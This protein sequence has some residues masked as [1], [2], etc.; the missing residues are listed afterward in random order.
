VTTQKRVAV[1]AVVVATFALAGVL[2]FVAADVLRWGQSVRQG[3]TRFAAAAGADGMWSP[4][5]LLPA[6]LSRGL[7]GLEDDL[8]FRSAV[9]RFRLARP[10]QPITQFS[11]LTERSGAE[12]A[13]ARVARKGLDGR[14]LAAIANL[15]GALALEE[16]RLESSAPPVRRAIGHFRRAV[17]LNPSSE[18][19]KFNLEL[20]LRLL[21][22]GAFT[23]GG[24]GSRE[25]TPASGAGSATAG[26]GY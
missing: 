10:R 1:A 22:G 9:Q 17:E 26:S 19:A 23:A 11:Q 4:R 20:A 8:E 3:D 13:L 14:R 16:A 12:R 5:T 15:R 6:A 2:A 25:A 7:L 21:S 24:G 18:D